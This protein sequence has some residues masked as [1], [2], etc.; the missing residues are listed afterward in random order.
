[1]KNSFLL[2]SLDLW[3]PITFCSLVA[4]SIEAQQISF[5][6]EFKSAIDSIAQPFIAQENTRGLSIAIHHDGKTTYFHYGEAEKDAGLPPDNSSLYEIG[7]VTKTFTGLLLA[8][9]ADERK[10]SLDDPISKY[11]PD[12]LGEW[13]D[14]SSITLSDLVTH[15]SGLPRIPGNMLPKMMVNMDNPYSEY[16][17][18]DLYSFLQDYNPIPREDRNHE[19]SNLGMGLL[20]H[21]LE[22]VE[23]KTY[24]ECL[25]TYIFTPLEMNASSISIEGKELI[26]GYNTQGKPTPHWDIPTLGGAGAIISN[27]EDMASYLEA[28]L[29]DEKLLNLTHQPISQFDK[30]REIGYA[31]LIQND[32][33]T[34]S[35]MIWHNGGTGGFTSFMGFYENSDMGVVVLSN[36]AQSVDLVGVKILQYLA[37]KN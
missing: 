25:K 5:S 26:Q 30:N 3:I 7:S 31:W 35:K 36:A 8:N 19:Y 12:G 1:M 29:S 10:V 9:L 21:I 6:P 34:N 16:H 13:N 27:I 14:G 23:G 17:V 22:L 11:L 20:G 33:E 4:I 2:K 32:T 18:E 28:N 24:E 15:H 37:G